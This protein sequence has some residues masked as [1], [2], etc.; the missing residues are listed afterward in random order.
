MRRTCK[1]LLTAP[2]AVGGGPSQFLHTLK[3][4][5]LTPQVGLVALVTETDSSCALGLHGGESSL[6]S[7]LLVSAFP[8]V[9]HSLR[10]I[11]LW[12]E[13]PTQACPAGH[14]VKELKP[15]CR[16]WQ[17]RGPQGDPQVSEKPHAWGSLALGPGPDPEAR[18]HREAILAQLSAWGMSRQVFLVPF[19]VSEDMSV[20]KGLVSALPPPR[21]RSYAP[22]T[23]A[24][25]IMSL[26]TPLI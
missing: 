3:K 7:D 12:S 20:Y 2:F 4:P 16:I 21:P 11:A 19:S 1:Q 14:V 26:P 8:G 17:G 6:W 23:K 18:T 25:T 13:S 5:D 22:L 10:S 15:H 9:G 24:A